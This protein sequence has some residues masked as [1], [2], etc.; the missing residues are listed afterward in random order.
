[1]HNRKIYSDLT[2]LAR[3]VVQIYKVFLNLPYFSQLIPL[4][5]KVELTR[6]SI[7]YG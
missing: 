2:F 3:T 5:Y 4:N 1:M 7:K 6:I